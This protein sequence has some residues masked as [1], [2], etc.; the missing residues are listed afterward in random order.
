MALG[1]LRPFVASSLPGVVR[2]VFLRLARSM[3]RYCGPSSRLSPSARTIARLLRQACPHCGRQAR[4]VRG[5][6]SLAPCAW[7]PL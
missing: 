6:Q 4:S 5:N 3:R 2:E 7:W 1:S